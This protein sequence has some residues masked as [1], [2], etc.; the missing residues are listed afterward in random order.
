MQKAGVGVVCFVI[1]AAALEKE[2][3]ALAA[4]QAERREQLR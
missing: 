1:Q 3:A 4:A 2:R